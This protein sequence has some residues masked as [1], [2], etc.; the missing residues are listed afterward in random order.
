LACC[1]EI[2]KTGM[3]HDGELPP[4]EAQELAEHIQRCSLCRQELDSLRAVSE[5]L[6]SALVPDIPPAAIERL[7]GCLR[8]RRDRLVLRTAKA[9]TAA[10][11]AV[12]LVCS[13]LAWRARQAGAG[14]VQ[15]PAEWETATVASAPAV[16]GPGVEEDAD[17]ELARSILG[18]NFTEGGQGYE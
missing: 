15:A 13:V 14:A 8:P 3:Y 7:R 6:S 11:A 1:K 9:L 16:P 17:V 10:A 12:L 2:R 4:S 5:W 18:N